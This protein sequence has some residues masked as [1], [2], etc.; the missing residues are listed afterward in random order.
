MNNGQYAT[1][2]EDLSVQF[3]CPE[4]FICSISQDVDSAEPASK[5]TFKRKNK[6]FGIIYSYEHRT[7]QNMPGQLYCYSL[8]S[9]KMGTRICKSYGPETGS[10]DGYVRVTIQ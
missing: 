3:T 9:D 7:A 4:D 8:V 5:V 6:N 1:N 10:S 2:V